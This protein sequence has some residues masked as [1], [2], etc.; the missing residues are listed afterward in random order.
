MKKYVKTV[1]VF[2]SLFLLTLLSV[3]AQSKMDD[4]IY[5]KNGS[6]IHGTIIETIPNQTVKIQTTG[7]NTI[8]FKMEEIERIAKDNNAST[9]SNSGNTGSEFGNIMQCS[10]GFFNPMITA[11]NNVGGYTNISGTPPLIFSY[12]R[13]IGKFSIGGMFIYADAKGDYTVTTA[14][15]YS[16]DYSDGLYDIWNPGSSYISTVSLNILFFG[17]L[18]NYHVYTTDQLDISL[19]GVLGYASVTG[20]GGGTTDAQSTISTRFNGTATYYFSPAIGLFGRVGTW[21]SSL[22]VDLG[23]SFRF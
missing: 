22:A 8:V 7:G 10:I 2:L 11:F 9:N 1:T 14:G 19:G 6:V 13:M 16:Y 18:G 23:A 17:L 15:Y 4:V 20:S 12:E 21:G 5:L 3:K